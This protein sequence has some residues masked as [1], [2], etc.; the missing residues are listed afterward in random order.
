MSQRLRLVW[1]G[2]VVGDSWIRRRR[3]IE[4]IVRRLLRSEVSVLASRMACGVE[5]EAPVMI[6]SAL[7]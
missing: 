6:L 7:A 3:V 1:S 2:V 4:A 5:L